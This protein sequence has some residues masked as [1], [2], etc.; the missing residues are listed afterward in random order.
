MVNIVLI[1]PLDTKCGLPFPKVGKVILNII[2]IR[3]KVQVQSRLLYTFFK[4]FSD[5]LLKGKNGFKLP[6]SKNKIAV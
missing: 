6:F 3:F 4:L 5:V 2:S 1:H